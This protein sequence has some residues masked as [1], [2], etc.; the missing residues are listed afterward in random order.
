MF[1]PNGL[2]DMFSFYFLV[3]FLFKLAPKR[4]RAT[5]ERGL[6]GK[7]PFYHAWP[8]IYFLFIF[9][10]LLLQPEQWQKCSNNFLS[11][12]YRFPPPPCQGHVPIKQKGSPSRPT[13]SPPCPTLVIH[14][15]C[16]PFGAYLLPKLLLHSPPSLLYPFPFKH[17]FSGRPERSVRWRALGSLQ[18]DSSACRGRV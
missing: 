14:T 9:K 17:R 8:I 5:S 7:T 4:V 13:E 10:K 2:V 15:F 6:A 1:P 12:S 18:H 11:F 16:G 3:W